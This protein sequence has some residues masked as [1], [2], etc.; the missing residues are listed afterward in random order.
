M[1]DGVIRDMDDKRIWFEQA[2]QTEKGSYTFW[3]GEQ[4]HFH[5]NDN[6]LEDP[7]F[8][9]AHV[10]RG[11]EP[12]GP[13]ISTDTKVVTFGS[14]FAAHIRDHL[15]A[16]KF[17]VLTKQ[18]GA[19]VSELGDGIVNTYAIRQQFEWAW[20]ER[21]PAVDL[22]FGYRAE[23]FGYS[24]RVRDKTRRLFDAA[25]VFILTLGLSEIWFD[26]PTGE[27]FWRAVP[28]AHFD[29]AR[30]KFRVATTQENLDNLH[31]IR[32]LIGRHRPDA[33]LV[34]TLSPIPLTA[35]FRPMSC[36]TADAVSKAV[37]RAAI[38]ELL[39]AHSG[40][41]RLFYFPSYEIVQRC[42]EHPYME[43]R[44]HVHKHVLDFNMQV[45]ERYFCTTGLSDETL[46]RRF[47]EARELDRRVATAGHWAVP[48]THVPHHPG[49]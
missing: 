4:T 49:P 41:E 3:R 17:N 30:H 24:T 20:E 40:D 34:I 36:L 39:R 12:K 7:G 29:P 23:A 44:R 10:M 31:A 19:Y 42:F 47:Q 38:D 22:W 11:L 16:L 46:F 35:T 13:I 25:D 21:Q 5:P 9:S 15:D 33:A 28:M 6:S 32:S 8:L 37:L 18:G 48:R 27:V 26:E 43:E 2:G 45:F 1:S 14:C